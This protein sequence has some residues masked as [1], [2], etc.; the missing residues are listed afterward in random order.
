MNNYVF[1]L[2]H[3]QNSINF[4]YIYFFFSRCLRDIQLL[5]TITIKMEVSLHVVLLIY[6]FL[7]IFYKMITYNNY[8]PDLFFG[9]FQDLHASWQY[10]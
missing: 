7:L 10:E 8:K 3:F 5:Y 1:V 9:S 4:V 6:K 2:F